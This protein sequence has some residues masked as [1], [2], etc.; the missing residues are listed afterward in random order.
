ML[1]SVGRRVLTWSQTISPWT[2]VIGFSRTLLALGTAITLLANE[3][4]LLFRPG[5]GVPDFPQCAGIRQIGTFCVAPPQHL[6]LTRWLAVAVLLLVAS[7]WR[8]RFTALPHWWITFSLQANAVVID[9]GDQISSIL[10]L[11]LLPVALTDERRWHWQN[12]SPRWAA[13]PARTAARVVAG[14]WLIAVRLQ[15]AGVYFH[16]A[17]GKLPVAEWA[18]GTALYYWFSDPVFGAPGWLQ[19][20]VN[21]VLH[22]PAVALLTWS[23]L[24]LELALAVGL[25]LPKGQRRVLLIAGIT[26]HGGIAL[27]HGL[28][29]FAM[30]MTAALILYLRPPEDVFVFGRPFLRCWEWVVHRAG[31]L[32]GN[33]R[34]ALQGQ[35][36][37]DAGPIV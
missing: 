6:E 26:F 31:R 15:V 23:I 10:T 25:L 36:V 18:D 3:T 21:A 1:T 9:G 2:N 24:V 12:A 16:A 8:P 14:I 33:H 35:P 7:G 22:V 32:P 13:A 29:S 20:V 28:A 30:A 11:L 34:E 27:I 19:P 5:S 4:S 17:V 37:A